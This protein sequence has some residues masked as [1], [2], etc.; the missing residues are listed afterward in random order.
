MLSELWVGWPQVSEQ[1]PPGTGDFQVFVRLFPAGEHPG[2]QQKHGESVTVIAILTLIS[3][4]RE[5]RRQE[6]ERE[7]RE[8]GRQEGWPDV[9]APGLDGP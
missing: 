6:R 3:C 9:R 7:G 5:E 2:S 4:K 1:Q 8:G